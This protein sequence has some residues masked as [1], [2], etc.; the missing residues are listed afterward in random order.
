MINC[1]LAIPKF[2]FWVIIGAVVVGSINLMYMDFT[3]WL[4]I[5]IIIFLI[6]NH[7]SK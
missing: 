2:I 1:L 7:K 5:G 6:Y 3:F 4:A